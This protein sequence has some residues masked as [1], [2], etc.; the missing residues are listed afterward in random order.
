MV[1]SAALDGSHCL[2][3]IGRSLLALLLLC[4]SIAHAQS[5][6]LVICNLSLNISCNPTTNPGTGTSGM[7]AWQ[8][9]GTLNQANITAWAT[10]Q[11]ALTGV[12]HT[13]GNSNATT[14]GSTPPLFA[15]SISDTPASSVNDYSPGAYAGGVTTRL[16][17]TAASGG[18]TITGLSA[19]GVPDGF[20]ELL[21]DQS[22]TDNL[23]LP[24]Q[25]SNSQ[26]V[27]RW[28][29]AGSGEVVIAP[30]ACVP[31][32]YVVSSWRVLL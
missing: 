25:S 28:L 13:S 1:A 3:R 22:S 24:N 21:C 11:P 29:N 27:N 18:T 32:S 8:A 26:S 12:I 9:N 2:T 5:P 15:S 6:P 23:I 19:T 30:N 16:L 7:P 4:A 20:S 10:L 31:I 17:I 14:W